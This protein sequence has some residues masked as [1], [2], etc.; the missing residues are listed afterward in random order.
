[1]SFTFENA[2]SLREVIFEEDSQLEFIRDGA[3]RNAIALQTIQI[4]ASVLVIREDACANTTNLRELSF[5]RNSEITSI[6]PTAFVGSGLT[7]VVMGEI[8]LEGLNNR[9]MTLNLPQLRFGQNSN[10]YGAGNVT[11]VSRAQQ[12]N[13]FAMIA[14]NPVY[15]NPGFFGRLLGKPRKKTRS[16]LPPELATEVGRYLMPAGVEP[17]SPAV[18]AARAAAATNATAGGARKPR[19]R[20]RGARRTQKR[21]PKRRRTMKRK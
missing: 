12:I 13:R 8:V 21:K 9:R 16:A 20:K 18:L 7:L 10:F 14:R 4:P 3:F 2:P 6:H 5:E 11:I 19:T 17:K 1:M 15:E